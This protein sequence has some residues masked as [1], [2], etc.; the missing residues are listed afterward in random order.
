M[1]L[2]QLQANLE[3][4][5]QQSLRIDGGIQTLLQ[6]I[7]LAEAEAAQAAIAAAEVKD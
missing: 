4:L 2:E 1:T 5:K 7:K 3:A 6:L